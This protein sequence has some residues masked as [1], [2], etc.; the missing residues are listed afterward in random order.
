[1][2]ASDVRQEKIVGERFRLPTYFGPGRK[3]GKFRACNFGR[4]LVTKRVVKS[5]EISGQRGLEIES[6]CCGLIVGRKAISD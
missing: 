2:K 4:R 6:Q 3:A 1:L 5:C